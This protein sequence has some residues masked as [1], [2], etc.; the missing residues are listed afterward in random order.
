LAV[1]SNF[2]HQGIGTLLIQRFI[3]RAKENRVNS[4]WLEVRE[5]NRDALNFYKN[6]KFMKVYKRKNFYTLPLEHADILKLDISKPESEIDE[7]T[8]R[9]KNLENPKKN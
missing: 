5:S 6:N 7:S 8:K 9:L 4:I 3:Q 2:R 1:K